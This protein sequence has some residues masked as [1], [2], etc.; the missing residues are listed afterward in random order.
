MTTFP[1]L[2]E[3]C[4]LIK[5]G[6]LSPQTLLSRASDRA[7]AIEPSL[8]AFVARA[9][10]ASITQQVKPGPLC[11]IPVGVKDIIA[12]VDLPTTNGSPI[13]K[14]VT[15][16]RDASIITRIR[17]LGGVIFGKTVTTEFAW[18]SPGPT[19]N[20]WSSEH[21]PGGSSSGS[22]AAVAAGI[23][24]LALGSQTQG[25]IIRPAAFCGVVGLKASYG[26]TPKE[27]V[28]PLSGSLDHIGFFTR[29]VDDAALALSLLKNRDAIEDES[30]VLDDFSFDVE[31][32][33]PALPR[34]RIA[35][36]ST[37]HDHLLSSEQ[38]AVLAEC[39]ECLRSGGAT[40][41]SLTLPDAFWAG[42]TNMNLIME[43]EGAVAHKNHFEHHPNMLG[44]HIRDLVTKGRAHSAVAYIEARDRQKALR[45]AVA[46][47]FSRFDAFLTAPATGEAPKGL[48]WTGD[49]IFCALWSF[50]GTPSITLPFKRSSLGLP[51]GIQLVGNCREDEKLLRVSKFVESLVPQ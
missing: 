17:A 2:L 7:D 4:R 50:L 9:T 22:A 27:G 14:G 39:A 40:L 12:T 34:P 48:S 26:A 41:E 25:S 23:V 19:T 30:I 35:L 45:K 11:G 37:P 1:G 20:P 33:V 47:Y 16:E 28:H 3:A 8:K 31:S 5:S 36:L 21:T 49:P 42:L 38:S 29:S 32:G 13:Y 24:P 15:P 10:S 44:E 43:C 51:L 46:S 18:R 6:A